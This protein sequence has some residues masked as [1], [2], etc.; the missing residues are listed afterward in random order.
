MANARYKRPCPFASSLHWHAWKYTYNWLD[1][2]EI[3][4]KGDTL[5]FFERIGRCPYLKLV[6]CTVANT[7]EDNCLL[8][9]V[10][11]HSNHGPSVGSKITRPL[12][13]LLSR[14]LRRIPNMI[15]RDELGQIGVPCF[16][17]SFFLEEG[18]R[19]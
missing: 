19:A 11:H 8:S 17:N 7:Q 3:I 9:V 2:T 13:R 1:Y 6:I 10:S 4:Q 14:P 5:A 12:S 15:I 16:T 18:E